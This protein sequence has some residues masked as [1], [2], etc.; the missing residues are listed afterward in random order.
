MTKKPP[1]VAAGVLSLP[2]PVLLAAR[3]ASPLFSCRWNACM[4]AMNF[5]VY[6]FGFYSVSEHSV[7][8]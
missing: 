5:L 7:I 6:V 1:R 8:L 2:L 3:F 4:Q